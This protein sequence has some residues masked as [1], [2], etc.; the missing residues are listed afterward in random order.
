MREGSGLT[1]NGKPAT[2]EVISPSTE[3]LVVYMWLKLMD[4]RLPELV[5]RVFATELQ[6]KS[7]KDIQP[8]I[9]TSIESLLAQLK[10]EEAMVNIQA[11]QVEDVNIAAARVP[12]T[13][14]MKP[15]SKRPFGKHPQHPPQRS[16]SAKR[17]LCNFCQGWG[18]PCWG[19]TMG[20]CK[21]MSQADK[22]DIAK[23]SKSY[24]V[25]VDNQEEEYD[26]CDDGQSFEQE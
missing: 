2:D 12:Q 3:R 14:F 10:S 21:F 23:R 19:H 7:L 11:L 16:Q 1:F 6:T 25:D 20:S 5:T 18:R 26:E 22:E 9:S 15:Q 24:R 13:P 17:L 4:E 8:Q